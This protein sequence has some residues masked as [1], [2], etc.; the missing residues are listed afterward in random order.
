M[1]VVL[2]ALP[3]VAAAG[4]AALGWWPL[5]G[6]VGRTLLVRSCPSTR[7]R[8]IA[9]TVAAVAFGA[10]GW[11]FG[12]ELTQP[13]TDASAAVVLGALLGFAA[14][15]TVL[16]IVDVLEHRLPNAVLGRAGLALAALLAVAAALDGGT[17]AGR[18]LSALVGAAVLF[19]LFLAVSLASPRAM[20]MGDVKLAA[21]VGGVLGWFGVTSWLYGVL[22]MFLLGGLAALVALAARRLEPGGAMP[23]GPAMLAGALLAFLVGPASLGP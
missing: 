11:R 19:G 10:L 20:G 17:G 4:G 16:G 23:F 21:L 13:A 6:W 14:A 12:G 8:A 5:A 1:P 3:L 7:I 9:A 15:G 22:A 2:A 18:A